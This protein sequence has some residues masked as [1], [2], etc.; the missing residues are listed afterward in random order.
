MLARAKRVSRHITTE[1]Q[2][3]AGLAALDGAGLLEAAEEWAG[4]QM[5]ADGTTMTVEEVALSLVTAG[6]YSVTT[7]PKPECFDTKDDDRW[8]SVQDKLEQIHRILADQQSSN[9]TKDWFTVNEAAKLIG[10]KP[11]TIRQS[12]NTGR[13]KDDWTEKHYR[14]GEWRIHRDAVEWMQNHGLPPIK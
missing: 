2:I 9:L 12:C 8:I 3:E 4:T 6:R 1:E 14:T 11:Y 13:L 7:L 10:F 5:F